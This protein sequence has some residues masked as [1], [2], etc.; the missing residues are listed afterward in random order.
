VP[1]TLK[2]LQQLAGYHRRQFNYPVIA[3]TGSNGKTVV[4]EWLY[5]LLGPEKKII[6]SPKS[7]NSQLGT[8]L[9]LWEMTAGHELAIFEA[10]ISREGEMEALEAMIKP[11]IGVLTTIGEAHNEGFSSR[12]KKISEKLSLFKDADLVVYSPFYLKDY[13]GDIPGKEKFTWN[14]Q[15][16]ADLS[17]IDEETLEEKYQFLRADFR[18][19]EI[20]C[21]LPFTDA[22]SIE[23]AVCCW[24]VLL[25]LGCNPAKAD[26]LLEKLQPIKM[27]L[28]LKTGINN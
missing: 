19:K 15:G 27:R 18:G 22:A 28:E 11:T 9:S 25:A 4:K 8:A 12:G 7:Y 1:D 16:A 2:A 23:N 10:G 26:N 3:I 13:K 20:Q 21:M 24:A 17:I 6:R 14:R 5:Q